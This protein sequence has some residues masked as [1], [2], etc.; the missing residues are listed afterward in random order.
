MNYSLTIEGHD[1]PVLSYDELVEILKSK[2]NYFKFSHI[3]G[4][5]LVFDSYLCVSGKN[6]KKHI[7]S[8]YIYIPISDGFFDKSKKYFIKDIVTSGINSETPNSDIL[9]FEYI[10][11]GSLEF[12]NYP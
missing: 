11:Y 12:F 2:I 1:D 10:G 3:M 7:Y 4:D 9:R 6:G 8:V 5:K